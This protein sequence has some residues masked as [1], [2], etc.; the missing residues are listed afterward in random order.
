M[1]GIG[2]FSAIFLVLSFCSAFGAFGEIEKTQN[3]LGVAKSLQGIVK[4]FF[5]SKTSNLRVISAQDSKSFLEFLSTPETFVTF[6]LLDISKLDSSSLNSS[7]FNIIHI[8]SLKDFALVLKG[9]SSRK[10]DPSG[11]FLLVID[12][13]LIIDSSKLFVF[14]WRHYIHNVNVLCQTN[15]TISIKTFMPFQAHSCGNTTPITVNYGDVKSMKNLYP[16]KMTNLRGCPIKLVTFFY[17]PITM[18]DTLS[19]G[20]SRYY[21]SEMD[22]VFGLADALNFTINMTYFPQSGSMGLLLENGTATGILKQTVDGETDMLMG[23]YYLTLLRSHYMSFSQ[24]H[25]SIP[26]IIMIPL[27]EPL[28]PFEKL[29][30]PFQNIV[31]GFL[32]VTFG[33]GVIVIFIINCNSKKVQ[34]FIYGKGIRNPYLNMINHCV[35]GNQPRLP[36]TNFAR[37]LVMM[38]L[39]FCLVQRSIYQSSLYLFLQSEG[40]NPPVSTIDEMIEKNFEFYIRETLEHNIRH[41]NFYSK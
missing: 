21:G 41:M 6:E 25:Y 37:S 26:L 13:C 10:I 38:F 32:L 23:F 12:N 7:S 31:W 36:K 30:R 16:E 27:G 5:A 39:L 18:R 8:T 3:N 24:S 1:N 40:R 34:D 35:G 17:P 11:F 22:L 14:A 28:S 19:N 33:S 2:I 9:I 15:G 4:N 29:F 20:S